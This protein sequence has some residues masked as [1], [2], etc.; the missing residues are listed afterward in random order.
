[1]S[2]DCNNMEKWGIKQMVFPSVFIKYLFCRNPST[3][4]GVSGRAGRGFAGIPC[5][6]MIYDFA[7]SASGFGSVEFAHDWSERVGFC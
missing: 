5:A 7:F 6:K 2:D 4:F 1:M 3:F